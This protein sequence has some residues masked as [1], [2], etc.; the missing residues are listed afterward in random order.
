MK[1]DSSFNQNNGKAVSPTNNN[2]DADE[3]KQGRFR[4]FQKKSVGMLFRLSL[5]SQI[6]L[7]IVDSICMLTDTNNNNGWKD[8]TT[9]PTRGSNNGNKT[10]FSPISVVQGGRPDDCSSPHT[11][12]STYGGETWNTAGMATTSEDEEDFDDDDDDDERANTLQDDLST[13]AESSS[14]LP[15]PKSPPPRKGQTSSPSRLTGRPLLDSGHEADDDCSSLSSNTQDLDL[16]LDNDNNDDL[17]GADCPPK[18]PARTTTQEDATTQFNNSNKAVPPRPAVKETDFYLRRKQRLAERNNSSQPA[19]NNP[20]RVGAAALQNDVALKQRAAR[21][22]VM[23]RRAPP[24]SMASSSS[25]ASQVAARQMARGG[26]APRAMMPE[27]VDRAAR[28]QQAAANEKTSSMN[29]KKQPSS[30]VQQAMLARNSA[31]R[32]SA[33]EPPRAVVSRGMDRVAAKISAESSDDEGPQLARKAPPPATIEAAMLARNSSRE[34]A[35]EPPRAVSRGMDRVAAKISADS[36]D[37][38]GPQLAPQRK[39]PPPSTLQAAMQARNASRATPGGVEP[40]R[41]VSRGMDRVAAKLSA[42]SSDDEGPQLAKKSPPS[43]SVQAAMLARNSSRASTGVGTP[44]TVSRGVDRAAAK[45]AQDQGPQLATATDNQDPPSSNLQAALRAR[46]TTRT[47][48]VAMPTSVSRTMDRAASKMADQDDDDDDG[49]QLASAAQH[50]KAPPSKVQQD[51]PAALRAPNKEMPESVSR[52]MDR[53][54]AK[55][56]KEDHRSKSAPATQDKKAPPSDLQAAMHARTASRS[57]TVAMPTSVSR[58]MDRAGAKIADQD[59]FEDEQGP[60]LASATNRTNTPPSDLQAAMQ[61]RTASRSS[62]VPMPTSVSRAMD[63]AGAKMA[64]T[65]SSDEDEEGP[66]LASAT[67]RKKEPPS[68]L[69]AAMQARTASR[70]STVPMPTSVSRAMDR[71]GAKMADTEFSD[72]EEEEGPQLAMPTKK[73]PP[74]DLQAAIQAR[75]ASRGSTVS[76]PTLVSRAM[77]SAGAKMIDD[78]SSDDEP[79]PVLAA[80]RTSGMVR[81]SSQFSSRR[82]PTETR[83]TNRLSGRRPPAIKESDD[84]EPTLAARKMAPG[85]VAS[86]EDPALEKK[87]EEYEEGE[88]DGPTLASPMVADEDESPGAFSVAL[89]ASRLKVDPDEDY[90]ESNDVGPRLAL[91]DD[92][93]AV[94]TDEEVYDIEEGNGYDASEDD[95]D[96][97][98]TLR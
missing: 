90:I 51:A 17:A 54:A 58:A 88:D 68:D 59:T 94:A 82:S 70:S 64:D 44:R 22:A 21:P 9:T 87:I 20:P 47:S 93:L 37:D 4:P 79:G 29:N 75:T 74:S 50:K 65:E 57:S 28:K 66:L 1:T 2:D 39:K 32:V 62:T 71:A 80:G 14:Q 10:S 35:V 83:S 76:L 43:S 97:E 38:E 52:A 56:A 91:Q 19:A 48:G 7:F 5:F 36:S 42:E 72:G 84:E 41:A 16:F 78:D 6:C 33:V 13:D 26:G 34:S 11:F 3:K 53:V 24:T 45:S 63:R 12:A 23:E 95:V 89:S 15:P 30:S 69:Q 98:S 86:F 92:F 55:M 85:A 60:M 18:P 96:M 77:D 49:P 73:A 8:F 67:N 81:D 40:P 27:A 46:T 61:A 31:S 25:L